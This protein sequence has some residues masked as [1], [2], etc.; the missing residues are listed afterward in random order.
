MVMIMKYK[1]NWKLDILLA[2]KITTHMLTLF[3]LITTLYVC[4]N[5]LYSYLT[6]IDFFIQQIKLNRKLLEIKEINYVQMQFNLDKI[7]DMTDENKIY[8]ANYVDFAKQISVIH[9]T[10]EEM[11]FKSYEFTLTEEVHTKDNINKATVS[12]KVTCEYEQLML[13]I[14]KLNT[15]NYKYNLENLFITNNDDAI[16]N[17]NA[18]IDLS[19]LYFNASTNNDL[20]KLPK[21]DNDEYRNPFR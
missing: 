5:Y 8:I 6:E 17:I 1:I 15:K 14:E 7:N 16:T 21:E 19:M 4:K 3:F 13:F 18:S 12:V 2:K 20:E 9:S 10:A 11:D